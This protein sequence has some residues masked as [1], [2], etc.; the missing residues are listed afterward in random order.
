MGV[1]LTLFFIGGCG[2]K[3][4]PLVT[5]PLTPEQQQKVL[6]EDQ[7]IDEE[8]SPNNKTRRPKTKRN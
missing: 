8:E 3:E 5:A 7:R 2:S 1:L 4:T 6:D